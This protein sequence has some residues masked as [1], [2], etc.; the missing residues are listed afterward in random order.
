[1]SQYLWSDA[2]MLRAIAVAS[3]TRPA[4]LAEVIVAAEAIQHTPPLD[5]ELHGAFTRLTDG[6][7]IEEHDEHFTLTSSVSPDVSSIADRDEG[8]A[9][10]SRFLDAEPWAAER[11]VKDPRNRIQFPGL[12]TERLEKANEDYSKAANAAMRAAVAASTV[13]QPTGPLELPRW[14]QVLSGLFLAAVSILCL[15][16]AVAVWSL[17]RPSPALFYVVET[18]LIA[19]SLWVLAKS[20]RL[21]TGWNRRADLIGPMGLEAFAWMFLLMPVAGFLLGEFS[22]AGDSGTLRGH[23]LVTGLRLL[24]VVGIFVGVRRLAAS[25]RRR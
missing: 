11:N 23:P 3:R 20:V 17:P 12:T 6:G 16:G 7:F 19:G 10:A 9:A 13:G 14:V 18:A 2:W 5:E 8:V 24:M 4:S 22:N 1:M 15:T 21:I 25:R